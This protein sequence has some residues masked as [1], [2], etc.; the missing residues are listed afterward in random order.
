M[1]SSIR[2]LTKASFKNEVFNYEETEI[3]LISEKPCVIKFYYD[4]CRPCE[5]SQPIYEQMN[6]LFSDNINF[7]MIKAGTIPDLAERFKLD[8][9]PV[10]VF[11]N[12]SNVIHVESGLLPNSKFKRI[13]EQHF[14]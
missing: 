14:N 1:L 10:F 7:F 9:M 12:K 5:Q 4:D 6:E 13:I 8:K 2:K 3:K 11:I